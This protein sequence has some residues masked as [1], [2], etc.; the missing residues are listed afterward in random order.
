MIPFNQTKIIC[1]IGPATESYEMMKKLI[2]AGMDTMRLNFSHSFYEEHEERL[3]I[4]KKLNEELGTN[5]AALLDTK[6]PEIRT[7]KF[8][9]GVATITIGSTVKIFMEEIL[10]DET[11]FSVTYPNL[12]L[13]INIGGTIVVDDGYLS[14]K[15]IDIDVKNR[16][17]ITESFNTHTIKDRRGI[18]VPG[19]KLN[20]DYISAKDKEDI[21]WGCKHDVDF[22]AA[23]F[24]RRKEDVLAIREI[25]E[26][27]DK[28]DIQ[29][30]A[31]IE[32]QEGVNN[33][34]EITDVADGVMIA[35]GDLGV[36]VPPEEVPVIQ[37]HIINM[38]HAKNKISI[39]ATQML[40]SMQEHPRPTRAEVSDVANA[41]LDGT[42]AIMLS[43]ESAIGKYPVESVNVMQSIAKRLEVEIDRKKIVDRASRTSQKDIPTNI[44]MSVAH[45][46]L[47]GHVDLIIAPTVSGNT[48]RILSKFRPNTKILAL[49]PTKKKARSLALNSCVHPIPFD[50]PTDTEALVA[51]SIEY[52]IKNKFV[53]SGDRVVITGGFPIGTKTN[54]F[55]ILEID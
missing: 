5:V 23:S 12:Y 7:H 46:V 29:I 28:C 39:T 11:Q 4:M 10:G 8:K 40:E 16:I 27:Q 44:A 55:R 17:I 14:L 42:D 49:V 9:D 37:K 25:L 43:G 48:A 50:L 51:L 41:I 33:L 18:N 34:N 1:T 52:A 32:N 19:M 22:I 45:S 20:L 53:R 6:G 35:R 26:S 30:I 21:L 47:Q 38:C 2:L 15:I 3:N 24:V 36:E 54:S 31:K 13:D